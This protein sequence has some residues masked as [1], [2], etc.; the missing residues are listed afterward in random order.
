MPQLA[1]RISGG[2]LVDS[3]GA[4]V[5]AGRVIWGRGPM[6]RDPC[7]PEIRTQAADD[8]TAC[9]SLMKWGGKEI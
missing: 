8:E 1:G 6:K 3:Y 5:L 7:L 2:Y 4:A 9:G